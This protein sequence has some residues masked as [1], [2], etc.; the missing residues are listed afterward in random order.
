[1]E[2]TA[3]GER[4]APCG[5]VVDPGAARRARERLGEL[6]AAGG[7]ADLLDRAWPTLAPVFAASPYLAAL[8]RRWPGA[9]RRVLA[10]SPEERLAGLLA[11]EADSEAGLRALKAETHLL[12]ALADL[13]GVW[14]LEAVTGALTTFADKAVR[15]A[16]GIAA[17]EAR[18]PGLASSCSKS[19]VTDTSLA[20]SASPWASTARASSTIRATSTSRCSSTRRP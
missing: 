12:T 15:A 10:E 16:F 14:D 17:R 4:I 9:L 8:S 2:E 11:A 13:G 6:A 5:P 20:C 1:M 18:A 3:L 19:I 7:W